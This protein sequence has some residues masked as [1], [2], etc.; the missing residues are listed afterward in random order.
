MNHFDEPLFD[1]G[2]RHHFKKWYSINRL[3]HSSKRGALISVGI[4]D[5]SLQ[6][7]TAII[8]HL[9]LHRAFVRILFFLELL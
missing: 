1:L 5:D 4:I 2:P 7:K 6:W 8:E 3:I 9:L